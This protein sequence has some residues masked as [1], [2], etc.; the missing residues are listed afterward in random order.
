MLLQH[1]LLENMPVVCRR[2]SLA[3]RLFAL[4]CTHFNM[5]QSLSRLMSHVSCLVSRVSTLVSCL[6]IDADCNTLNVR[7]NSSDPVVSV[8]A[9]L[10]M[11]AEM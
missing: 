6:S 2:H 3:P 4:A 1:V 9:T 11:K 8:W 10:E 7:S 5:H